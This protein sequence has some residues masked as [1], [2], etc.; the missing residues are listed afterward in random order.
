M[1]ISLSTGQQPSVRFGEHECR[2]VHRPRQ[3]SGLFVIPG[4]RRAGGG[5]CLANAFPP[6][7]SHAPCQ[8]L[9]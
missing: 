2:Y 1:I 8:N 6:W 5:I 4:R 3:D 9:P 7:V